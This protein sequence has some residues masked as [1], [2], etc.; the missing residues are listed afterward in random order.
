MKVEAG[1]RTWQNKKKYKD[2]K[3][4]LVR[5]TRRYGRRNFRRKMASIAADKQNKKIKILPN[6]KNKKKGG[7]K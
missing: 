2:E 5:C 1:K 6:K 7:R 3:S 4:M